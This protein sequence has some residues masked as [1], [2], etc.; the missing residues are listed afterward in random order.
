MTD[1]AQDRPQTPAQL[2]AMVRQCQQQQTRAERGL[3][4][5]QR[6]LRLAVAR[7]LAG[8]VNAND[9]A[10]ELRVTRQRVY[11]M[12]DEALAPREG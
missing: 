7:A 1:Q 9:L 4:A 2:M 3:E 12:K 5:R 10:A 8:G 11:Q 6:A